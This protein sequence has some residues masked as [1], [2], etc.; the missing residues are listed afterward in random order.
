M[1][2]IEKLEE[3]CLLDDVFF[4]ACFRHNEAAVNLML[5]ILLERP[6]FKVEKFELQHEIQSLFSHSI[7]MDVIASDAKGTKFNVEIQ[8]AKSE[9]SPKRVRY[10]QGIIDI[11]SL[12][13]G[14]NYKNLPETYIIFVLENDPYGAGLPLYHIDSSIRELGLKYEPEA[15]IIFANAAYKEDKRQSNEMSEIAKLM[16]D[17]RETN[18]NKMYFSEF[19]ERAK[20]Y[21]FDEGGKAEMNGAMEALKE[22]AREQSVLEVLKNLGVTLTAKGFGMSVD[23]VIEIAKRNGIAV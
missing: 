8:N 11:D 6:D 12:P 2:A 10:Y 23:A 5:R 19:S 14:A 15:H 13:K 18:P 17:M 21:K 20:Y 9:A 7:R 3:Y 1:D 4:S 16:S 22:E